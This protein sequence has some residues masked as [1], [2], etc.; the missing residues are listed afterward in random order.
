MMPAF[1]NILRFWLLWLSL[2]PISTNLAQPAADF[3]VIRDR[4]TTSLLNTP[5]NAEQVERIITSMADNGTWP[6]IN[7]KDTS[8]TGF[9]HRIHLGNLLTMAKAYK[10]AGST[11]TQDAQLLSAFKKA[12]HHWLEKDYRCENWWWNEIGTPDAM[13]NILLLMRDELTADELTAGLAIASRSN[14]DAFGAR[15]GGDFIKMAAINAVTELVRQDT[16]AFALAIKTMSDQI[17]VTEDRGIKPDMSFHHRTD[18][19]PSTLSYGRQY[20]SSFAYWAD[21]VRET[22]FAFDPRAIALVV[23]YYLDGMRKAMPF[24]RFDDPGIKNRDVSRKSATGHRVD[25]TA[26]LLARISSYRKDELENPNLRSNQYFWY[27]H[28]HSHQR[29]TYF[30][31]VRMYSNRSNNIESPYNEEGLKNHFYADGSQ[32]ISRTGREYVNIYPSWDWRKIPGTTVVQVDTFP[33]SETLVK[34]GT[35]AFVG[36]ISDGEYG[37]TTFDLLSPHSGL[38]AHKSWFFF[39]DEIVC[40]GAGITASA[41]QPVM[42]T[43]NQSLSNGPVWINDKRVTTETEQELKGPLWLNHDSIGYLVLDT[44]SVWLRQGKSSGT[45]RSISHQDHATD[46]PVTQNIFTLALDHGIRPQD[47]TYAYMVLPA[48]SEPQTRAYA[49][50]QPVHIVSNTKELQAVSHGKLGIHYAIFYEPGSVAFP[51][52]LRITTNEPALFMIKSSGDRIE[53]ITVADPTRKLQSIT[54]S[55]GLATDTDTALTVQLPQGVLAGKSLQ[56]A[57]QKNAVTFL[58]RSDTLAVHRNQIWKG[59]ASLAAD[60]DTVLHAANKALLRGP[61]SVVEKEKTPP[62]GDKH[63]YMS[64]G[65][66][67]WPDT[68]KPDGLPYIRKDGQVNPERFAINDAQNL[69]DLCTDVQ[70]L[71][72]SYYFTQNNKYAAHA[73]KLLDTWFLNAET[74]MNPNLNFGQSIPGI[75]DGR[76]IGLIDT[77]PLVK[78]LDAT[79]LLRTSPHWGNQQHTRLQTWVTEFLRWMRESDIGK[80]EAD[81][82]NNHGTYY[83]VQVASYALFVGDTALARQ[84]LESQTKARLESQLEIDGSQPHELAR[85]RSWSYS[86]M[87]LTGFFLTA[88]LGENIGIDLWNYETPQGKSIRKAFGYLLPYGLHQQ[89]WTYPQLGGMDIKGFY[90]LMLFGGRH[91]LSEKPG[92]N[93]R[94]HVPPF[95][96]LTGSFF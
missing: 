94:G 40:L 13:A 26:R 32:F 89:R 39:D 64:V 49:Q 21:L 3:M 72:V 24:G 34:K 46:E 62:S 75:T 76:G 80:D 5:V 65:P 38:R 70:L 92:Q 7:Y 52:G 48:A 44:N 79:Q 74:R 96:R 81:E 68:T 66:Y 60:L 57:M 45:W 2:L 35:T 56:L 63:D 78:L 17:Y 10:Q 83:D 77:W 28:Y 27:S 67:W 93:N 69:K 14:F 33:H 55:V 59:D 15:P 22:R 91:Y 88:R 73:A 42:T 53:R 87:N 47:A 8:R 25:H 82:H 20:A 41:T 4:L 90:K 9:E 71:A 85:T 1:K 51:E 84:T 31:S 54:F 11:Y 58:L 50:Q 18:G 19:V 30:A 29:P 43:L 37:A 12:Y 23:D 6:T 86:L 16:A 61:Y 36:G 95:N